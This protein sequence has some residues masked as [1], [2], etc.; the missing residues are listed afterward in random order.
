MLEIIRMF[1]GMQ[2]RMLKLQSRERQ[3]IKQKG[4][5]SALWSFIT[6]YCGTVWVGIGNL[7]LA[8]LVILIP[9]NVAL[10]CTTWC[11][12]DKHN[13]TWIL[14]PFLIAVSK[15]LSY[16]AVWK[17]LVPLRRLQSY[18]VLAF[19]VYICRDPTCLSG[20]CHLPNVSR[21]HFFLLILR[22]GKAG[23]ARGSTEPSAQM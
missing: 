5:L 8:S 15:R 12:L 23:G 22:V 14:L 19:R 7:W 9:L 2:Y 3:K 18:W 20:T 16:S 17:W 10:T 1:R 21:D 11:F 4:Q 6:F 13:T